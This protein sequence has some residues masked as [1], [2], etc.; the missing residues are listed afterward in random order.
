MR[1]EYSTFD[2]TN[3]PSKTINVKSN[4]PDATNEVTQIILS[5]YTNIIWLRLD[6]SRQVFLKKEEVMRFSMIGKR[7]T[8]RRWK[9]WKSTMSN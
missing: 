4:A 3:Q 6:M 2:V 1:T 7:V 5:L 8:R 9:M